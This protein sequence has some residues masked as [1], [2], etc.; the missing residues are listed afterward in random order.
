MK[1]SASKPDFLARTQELDKL[2]P[3]YKLRTVCFS[4]RKRPVHQKEVKPPAL[5]PTGCLTCGQKNAEVAYYGERHICYK[6]K[7]F[8]MTPDGRPVSLVQTPDDRIF[9]FVKEFKGSAFRYLSVDINDLRIFDKP[10]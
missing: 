6:C 10:C 8:I 3:Q 4:Y 5:Y 2:N 1:R 9:A 7:N